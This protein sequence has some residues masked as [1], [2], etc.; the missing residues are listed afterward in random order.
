M[1]DNDSSCRAEERTVNIHLDPRTEQLL[2]E[3]LAHGP[4]RSAEELIE[5]A[6]QAWAE[7]SAHGSAPPEK[8]A[9][10]FE[11]FLDAFAAYSDKIP[12]MPGG[13][14]SREMIYQDHP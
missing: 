11:A 12:A 10:E 9:E 7:R 3:Q 14:F 8:S 4:F 13:T 2:K 6:L 5:R 1:P